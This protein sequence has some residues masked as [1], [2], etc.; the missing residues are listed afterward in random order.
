[1]ILRDLIEELQRL[2]DHGFHSTEVVLSPRYSTEPG[3]EPEEVWHADRALVTH[4]PVV[5][6]VVVL[7]SD[8]Y[9]VV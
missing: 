6:Q 4:L 5:G 1:M 9:P 8:R 7:T 2:S 3:N